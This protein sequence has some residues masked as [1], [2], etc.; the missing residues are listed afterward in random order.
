[1]R[2]TA[3]SRHPAGIPD[4]AAAARIADIHASSS[5]LRVSM[6]GSR[7]ETTVGVICLRAVPSYGLVLGS[8]LISESVSACEGAAWIA[9]AAR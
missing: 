6:T 8:E 5:N 4:A 2:L 3:Q 9:A 7:D 1:M